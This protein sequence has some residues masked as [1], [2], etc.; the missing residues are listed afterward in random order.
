MKTL[1]ITGSVQSRL[2]PFAENLGKAGA[3]AARPTT[4]D[5]EMT[6]AAW[7][8][9]VLAIQ[10][11]HAYLS[12]VSAPGRVWEQLAGEIFLANHNQPVWYWA[13]TGST[14]LL[15]FWF[16]FDPNTFFLL[17]HASPHEA[18]MDAIEYGADTLEV[19]QN[20][21]DDWYQRTRQML[22]FHLRHPT[23]SILLDS[24]DALGQPDAYIDVLAQRWQLP[25][26]TIEIEQTWQN[27]PHHLT[28]YL[29]DKFLQNQPQALALHH[30]VQAS[31]F[32][33]NDSKAPASK[34]ELGDVLSDYLETRRLFQAGQADN[35]TLRQTLKAAQSQLADTSLALQDRQAK[36]VNLETDHQHLQAQSEQ[37][38][39][40]LSEIR[41]GLEN[42]NQ[43]NQLLL[44]QLSHTLE[45][46]EKLAQ[47]DRHKSQQLTELNVERNTL[48]SQID[49]FA[50]EKT[51]LA[52]AH[53]E[54]AKLA[55]EHKTQIDTLFKE[56]AGLVAARDTL[57]K[58]KTELVATRDALVKEKT[59]LAAAHDEQARLANEHKTQIDTLSKEK[60]G[61]VAARDTLSKEKTELTA[62]RDALVKEKTALAAAHDEQARLAN[63][64]KTQIDTLSKEKAGLVA[65]RDT[66]SKE[67]TELTAAR[68]A[69][70]KEK[71]ALTATCDEQARL[72]NEHKTQIDTLS[73][74]KAGLVAARDTLSKEKAELAAARDALAKEKIAL[75]ATC[76]EYARLANERKVQIDAFSR[77]KSDLLASRDALAKEKIA[78]A[79]AHDELIK[80]ANER[81]S[82][83]DVLSKE[84]TELIAIR[85]RLS[86][87]KINLAAARDEHAR[88]A[89]KRQV[90]FE[91]LSKEAAELIAIRDALAKEKTQLAAAHGEQAKLA[92]EREVQINVLANEK[93][94]LIATYSEQAKLLNEHKA[95]IDKLLNEKAELVAARYNLHKE[96]TNLTVARDTLL[97]ETPPITETTQKRLKTLIAEKTTLQ[98]N[99]DA[100]AKEYEQQRSK[101]DES[102]SENQQLLIQLH[103]TQEELERYLLQYQSSQKQLGKQQT[104]LQKMLQR[105]PDYWDF[106]TLEINLVESDSS[107]QIV[108]WRLTELYI[109][110]RLIPEIRFKTCL[111][112][113]LAGIVIQRTEGTGSPAPLLRWPN[114]FATA[115]ELP[116]I[117]TRGPST[118]GNN[119]A[120]SGLGTSDWDTLQRLAK[121]LAGFLAQPTENRLPKQ[122][123]S[124]ALRNG[125][126]AFAKALAGWP[127]MLRYDSIQ[128]QEAL[129]NQGY[130][131]LGIS[132]GNLCLGHRH[133]P[134]FDYRLATVDI[135]PHPFGQ[136]PR[137]EFPDGSSRNVLQNWF[138]ESTDSHGS[139]L[140]LRFA[141]PNAM[142]T[143]V[144]GALNQNDQQLIGAL[145][146][147][148]PLQ[149]EDL[150]QAYPAASRPWQDWQAMA[151]M[152]RDTLRDILI[153]TTA[154]RGTPAGI[155]E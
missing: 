25:L 58:E 120:L 117:P 78:L 40:E 147:T 20:T 118:Q 114:G 75:T 6:I 35:D 87:E 93:S 100:F 91:A 42:S 53:D 135:E 71:T 22:R 108:Q 81:K 2:D 137:L 4:R 143:N 5:Q 113:G 132:L 51:A 70:A 101:L 144:W 16:N 15:D 84:K 97:K 17:L 68:D 69:L 13:D 128:L 98:A 122:L 54:Q 50:K 32:L 76:D 14:L 129:C 52:A 62:T 26:E 115:E 45:N 130:E 1:C 85:D 39:Q 80:L 134:A 133:W 107:Q 96:K 64:H 124:A 65:A 106:N 34:P 82:Q 153:R 46:L 9:K 11:D 28:L 3:S 110:E 95:Q 111:A 55:N 41:S 10:K 139:R 44:E 38:L 123:N 31:L 89:N 116:C 112:N 29:V 103:Q 48:L 30:E 37:Y 121:H 126:L 125:L 155:E 149:L 23:R 154:L 88:L 60:A 47:E 77:E 67:K 19:L 72:A 127:K 136:N 24:N 7:H 57:S 74:E 8:R 109:G 145:I 79:V 138:A 99:L 21:L 131:R 140:E 152:L 151:G 141:Q 59:A 105:H 36:L 33:I 49:L 150:K 73:K 90:Q 61:L 63:E 102:E 142:D 56:K 66:L 104:R 83:V 119:A 12:S 43:E 18:L 94:N 146:K 27:N 92:S 86:K 148:L